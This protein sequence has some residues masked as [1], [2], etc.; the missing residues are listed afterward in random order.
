MVEGLIGLTKPSGAAHHFAFELPH[1]EIGDF[2]PPSR[3][4]QMKQQVGLVNKTYVLI[5]YNF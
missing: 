2:G 4:G 3:G 5:V 1:L